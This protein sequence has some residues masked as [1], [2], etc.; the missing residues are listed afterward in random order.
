M[1]D[2]VVKSET[3]KKTEGNSTANAKENAKT[4]ERNST[5][6]AK[7]NAKTPERNSTANVKGNTK[8]L[9]KE[10]KEEPSKFTAVSRI[11]YWVEGNVANN[12]N[13]DKSGA[14]YLS[15]TTFTIISV[16]GGFLALDHLY[17]RSPMTFIAKLLVNVTCFG[18]WWIWDAAQAL[19]NEPVVRIYGLGIPGLGPKGIGAGV[20]VEEKSDSKHLRF[21]TYAVALIFG[22]LIGLDSF[23]LGQTNVGIFRLIATL[24]FVLMPAS[25]LEWLGK[26]YDFFF[27]TNKVVAQYG[28]YFGAKQVEFD[29]SG[30]IEK[31]L[32]SVSTWINAYLQ[33]TFGP[34][35]T[36]ITTAINGVTGAYTKTL[37]VVDTA[38]K[39]G[40]DITSTVKTVVDAAKDSTSLLPVTSLYSAVTTPAIQDAKEKIAESQKGGGDS[41]NIKLLPFT[42]IGTILLIFISGLYKNFVAKKNDTKDDSPPQ[43]RTVRTTS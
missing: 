12:V 9:D 30:F 2:T 3:D 34:V 38:I 21:F 23:V 40:S 7:E 22:G 35:I 37:D 16:L 41:N 20:L 17:L 42:L 25:G 29:I 24:T 11:D 6:N 26:L 14:V 1:A 43:P 39:A 4:P 5:A 10:E 8:K 32:G 18:A 19:F 27:N 31:I 28:D 13:S 36:P 15:Y 33:S